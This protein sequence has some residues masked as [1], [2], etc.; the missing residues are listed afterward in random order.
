MVI[1]TYQQNMKRY[2][3]YSHHCRGDFSFTHIQYRNLKA[4]EELANKQALV[5]P[6][7]NPNMVIK[8]NKT[9]D[10]KYYNMIHTF[11]KLKHTTLVPSVP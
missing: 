8:I 5:C 10:K 11:L 6:V 1:F 3:G 2:T 4:A 7:I 9:L